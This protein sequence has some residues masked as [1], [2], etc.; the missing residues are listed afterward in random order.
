MLRPSVVSGVG[1][2][3]VLEKC[4]EQKKNLKIFLINM[5]VIFVTLII[6]ARVVSNAGIAVIGDLLQER[7]LRLFKKQWDA[8]R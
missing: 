5:N 4:Q 8:H 1:I 3:E 2:M 6:R 7:C